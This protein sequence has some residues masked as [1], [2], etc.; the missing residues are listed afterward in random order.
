MSIHLGF[1]MAALSL[2]AV[3]WLVLRKFLW[4]LPVPG[5]T[6]VMVSLFFVGGL[7]IANMGMVGVY[8][9]RIFEEVK[10]RPIYLARETVGLS[11]ED[12]DA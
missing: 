5:W 9:A 6:S 3:A 11:P 7:L 1:V 10:S 12:A 4:A 8:I 2:V